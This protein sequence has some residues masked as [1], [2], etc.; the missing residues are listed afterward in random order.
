MKQN[1]WI[2]FFCLF[3]L[4]NIKIVGKSAHI[5]PILVHNLIFHRKMLER[6]HGSRMLGEEFA[7]IAPRFTVHYTRQS[8]ANEY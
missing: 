1:S 3:H 7:K 4:Y 5:I 8:V 2:Q 6:T